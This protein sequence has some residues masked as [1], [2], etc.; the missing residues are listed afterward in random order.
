MCGRFTLKT[1]VPIL[2]KFFGLAEIPDLPP[3]FNVAPTQPV[4]TVLVLTGDRQFKLMRWGLVPPWARDLR[5]GSTMINARAETV[6]EKPSFRTALR[7]RRCIVMADGF[8]EWDH[9]AQ[10]RQPFHIV[11]KDGTPLGFAGLW[12]RWEPSEGGQQVESCTIIT[13]KANEI[14]G[15]LH[16]RMPVILE[17]NDYDLWLDPSVHEPERLLP[18]LKQFP[19]EKMASHPVSTLVNSPANESA[20]C[21]EPIRPSPG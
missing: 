19:A 2:A 17:P 11:N 14:V 12:E 20:A 13:T 15:K 9:K 16:D 1:P 3:R 7:E 5:V 18:L 4:A 8:Y 21:L 10:P 6:A